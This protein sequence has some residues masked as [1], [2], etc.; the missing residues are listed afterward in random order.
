MSCRNLQ[1]QDYFQLVDH[2]PIL[3]SHKKTKTQSVLFNDMLGTTLGVIDSKGKRPFASTAI[4]AFGSPI[5]NNDQQAVKSVRLT[6][7]FLFFMQVFIFMQN[8]TS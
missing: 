1:L 7:I 2:D 8:L 3:A 5:T 4:T 6:T